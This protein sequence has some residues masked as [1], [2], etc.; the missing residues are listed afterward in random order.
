MAPSYKLLPGNERNPLRKHRNISCPCKSGKKAKHCH[1]KYEFLPER[2]SCYLKLQLHSLG[3]EIL[4][5]KEVTAF[6]A[7]VEKPILDSK[8]VPTP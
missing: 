5:A 3:L 7:I 4:S 8:E 6:M 1:G 2:V